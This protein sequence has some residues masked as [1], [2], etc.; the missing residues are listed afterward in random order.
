MHCEG[1]GESV[2]R[3]SALE[4]V[5][6]VSGVPPTLLPVNQNPIIID[7]SRHI[8]ALRPVYFDYLA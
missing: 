2:D 3:R 4:T 8:I 7:Y 5:H 6:S 1:A